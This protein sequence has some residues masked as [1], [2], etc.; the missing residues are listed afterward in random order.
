MNR[1]LMAA[2]ISADSRPDDDA[3]MLNAMESPPIIHGMLVRSLNRRKDTGDAFEKRRLNPTQSDNTIFKISKEI[4][5][6]NIF[7]N[8]FECRLN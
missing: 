2:I 4:M 3:S 1:K 5:C 8:I 6:L 7:R